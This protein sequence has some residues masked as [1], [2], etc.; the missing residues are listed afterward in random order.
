MLVMMPLPKTMQMELL[1]LM[2]VL[3]QVKKV[4]EVISIIGVVYMLSIKP[5]SLK[6]RKLIHGLRKQESKKERSKK[7]R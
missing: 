5:T 7:K 1:E 6:R 3:D 2:M 4:R